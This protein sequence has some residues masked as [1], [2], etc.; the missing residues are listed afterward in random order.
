MKL[1]DCRIRADSR[2]GVKELF[3]RRIEMPAPV[4]DRCWFAQAHVEGSSYPTAQITKIS[5]RVMLAYSESLINQSG[6]RRPQG[7]V[8]VLHRAPIKM[9][10]NP[11]DRDQPIASC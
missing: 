5:V 4:P 1:K 11:H 2:H 7:R 6:H 9:Q 8:R 3:G 10:M